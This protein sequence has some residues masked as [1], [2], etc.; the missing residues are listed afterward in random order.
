ML[1]QSVDGFHLVF[2]PKTHWELKCRLLT[3]APDVF[4]L[5]LTLIVIWIWSHIYRGGVEIFWKWNMTLF[6]RR[7]SIL[8]SSDVRNVTELS[9]LV[10]VYPSR[11]QAFVIA[12][13]FSAICIGVEAESKQR[14]DL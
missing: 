14:Q 2:S 3:I 1:P 10:I 13:I 8:P 7:L 6:L 4:Q 12:F 5:K 11:M 9:S